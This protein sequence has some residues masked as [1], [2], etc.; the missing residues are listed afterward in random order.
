MTPFRAVTVP[1]RRFE[2]KIP[3]QAVPAR[4]GL[5]AA[6]PATVIRLTAPRRASAT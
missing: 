5:N 1:G 3:L 6:K 2:T 4:A